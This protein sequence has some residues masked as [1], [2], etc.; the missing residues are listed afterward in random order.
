M[1]DLTLNV[2][3]ALFNY[4]VG[5]VIKKGG[6]VLLETN[7]SIDFAVIPGGRVTILE[8]SKKALKREIKEEMN[9]DLDEK[10]ISL[11][12]L[13]ENF[14]SY[15]GKE[16][17]EMYI[18]YEI[19]VEEKDDRFKEN[20]RNLDSE[21]NFYKWMNKEELNRITILPEALREVINDEEFSHHI[22]LNKT[23]KQV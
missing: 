14:F 18:V 10:E 22:I 8:D 17:H 12:A 13:M 19:K 9:I 23:K 2:G 11:K 20:M 6:K 21:T 7:P 16:V 15:E 4:R 3:D 1:K 5:L